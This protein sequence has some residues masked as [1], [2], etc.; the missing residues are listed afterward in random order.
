[1]MAIREIARAKVNLTL[2]VVGR[3]P[4]GY[5]E[6][7]SLVTFADFGDVVTLE[8]DGE[9][10]VTSSGP[11]AA[12]I[13]GPNLLGKALDLLRTAEPRLRLGAV[14]LEKSLPVAAGLGGGSA[15][16]AALL[17]AVREANPALADGVP[18]VQL[19]ARLG[20]D[21][22]VCLAGRPA[23]ISGVGERVEP[24][25]HALPAMFAVLVNPRQALPTA[26]VYGALHA[27]PASERKTQPI[28]PG[29][30]HNLE[31]LV[32]HMRARGNDLERPAISLLPV[33]ANVKASIAALPGC[34]HAALSGSG[35]TCFG[36]FAEETEAAQAAKMLVASRPDYWVA[37]TRLA[38]Q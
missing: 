35:P 31:A 24:L 3:R 13:D 27:A 20:A 15:D 6:I 9:S 10:K 19:A 1:M 18:W 17:R 12:A 32:D 4:D 34:H 2:S 16:A 8:P 30:F 7:E 28:A 21:V 37:A 5:H 25:A 14:T 11:F 36:L 38:A 33:I 29:P 23:V 26:A 22:S